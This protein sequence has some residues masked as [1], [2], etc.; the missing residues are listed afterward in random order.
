MEQS[1]NRALF[2]SDRN[3]SETVEQAVARLRASGRV[4]AVSLGDKGI[5]DFRLSEMLWLEFDQSRMFFY[6]N[7]VDLSKV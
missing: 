2:V 7:T 3:P 6:H 4:L 5:C 1:L